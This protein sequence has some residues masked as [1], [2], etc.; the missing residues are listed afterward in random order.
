MKIMKVLY[1]PLDERPCNYYYPQMM[2]ESNRHI[3]LTLPDAAYLSHK[4][5][6]GNYK[7]IREYLLDNVQ[8]NDALILSLDMLIYGGLLASRLHQ[9]TAEELEKRLKIVKEIDEMPKI[10]LI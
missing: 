5:Q 2:A 9:N 3:E 10:Q 6:A 7:K 4:K 8:N 1:L